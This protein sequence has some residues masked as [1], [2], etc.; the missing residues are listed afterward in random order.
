MKLTSTNGQI[1]W[2]CDICEAAEQSPDG[3]S[4]LPSGW[5]HNEAFRQGSGDTTPISFCPIC[6]CSA[7]GS[8]NL[9][10]DLANYKRIYY[11]ES[12]CNH[13]MI[14]HEDRVIFTSRDGYIW[15]KVSE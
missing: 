12:A 7:F 4:A 3:K 5:Y 10:K 2:I 1:V 15:D 14:D 9:R 8:E 13:V 11:D 6:T